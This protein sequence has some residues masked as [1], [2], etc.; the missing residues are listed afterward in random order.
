[1]SF[2]L[3]NLI[4]YTHLNTD[5]PADLAA[6]LTILSVDEFGELRASRD[7]ETLDQASGHAR[8]EHGQLSGINLSSMQIIFQAGSKNLEFALEMWGE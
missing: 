2:S 3:D 6:Q 7:D 4:T 5:T 1:M 8:S